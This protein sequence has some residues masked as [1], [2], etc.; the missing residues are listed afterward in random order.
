MWDNDPNYISK[1]GRI[2]Q[3]SDF[4]IY[5]KSTAS[6]YTIEMIIPKNTRSGLTLSEGDSIGLRFLFEKIENS[7][8]DKWA[9]AFEQYS[10]IKVTLVSSTDV[11]D[12][13]AK[14]NVPDQFSLE[15]NYPNPFN[16][17]TT[18]SFNLPK[19]TQTRLIIYNLV[20]QKVKILVDKKQRA[21]RY[22]IQWDGKD[23]NGQDCPSGIYLLMLKIDNYE[24]NK[25]LILL[26]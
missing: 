6:G 23:N 17:N 15:Q 4:Q 26:R 9:T 19:L 20:G 12:Q 2:I 24:D 11:K 21:G 5:S 18:I 13:T 16:S 7:S 8:W 25:K 3:S 14:H 1:F 10:F 22:T